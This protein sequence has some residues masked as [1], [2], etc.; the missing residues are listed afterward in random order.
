MSLAYSRLQGTDVDSGG[1]SFTDG[2]GEIEKQ[3]ATTQPI[4]IRTSNIQKTRDLV[5]VALGVFCLWIT[6]VTA[7]RTTLHPVPH[8][9]RYEK[10]TL[11]CGNTTDEAETLGC[12]FDL[13]SH[14]W[15]APPCLDPVTESE[16]RE[17]ISSTNRTLGPYPYF[18][19]AEGRDRIKDERAFAMLANGPGLANQHVYTTREE[20][21]AHCSF[22]LRR[23]H[24]AAEGKVRLNDENSQLWHTKHCLEELRHADRKPLDE[25]NEGFFIGFAPCT[26]EVP[27]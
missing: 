1:Q 20:H 5:L 25:L 10:Q 16:Y 17:Y 14:N 11:T 7:W 13:L 27:V 15:V 22:L 19:D 6:L 3:E 24:R 12:A 18:L 4:T 23:T 26:I 21:L 9:V 2:E 8:S